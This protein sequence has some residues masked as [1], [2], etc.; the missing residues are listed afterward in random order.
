MPD[1]MMSTMLA[2]AALLIGAVGF[3]WQYRVRAHRRNAALD[4]YADREILRARS[5]RARSKRSRS[6]QRMAA[7]GAQ[8]GR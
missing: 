5:K 8:R 6:P 4:A 3:A 7:A 2:A 1:P